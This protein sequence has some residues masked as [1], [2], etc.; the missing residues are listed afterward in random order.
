MPRARGHEPG[1]PRPGSSQRSLPK[2]I[3]RRREAKTREGS[4]RSPSADSISDGIVQQCLQE[5]CHGIFEIVLFFFGL[6][7]LF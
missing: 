7:G 4:V 5:M 2:A 1:F 6:Q 3:S